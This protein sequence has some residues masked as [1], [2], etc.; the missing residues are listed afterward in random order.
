MPSKGFSWSYSKFKNYFTCAKRHYEVDLQRNFVD[1]SE[2]LR[3][4]NEVHGSLATA[5]SSGAPLPSSMPYQRWADE[6]RTGVFR[7]EVV[8]TAPWL[9]H[10][11]APGSEVQVEKKYAI[12]K[13]FTPT[14]WFGGDAW[15]R[16]ICDVARFDP[17]KTVALA[18]DYKTGKV[19]HD[20]RQLMLM[21]QCLFCHFPSLQRIRTEFVWLKEDC[22]TPE[23][24]NR[25]T[26]MQEWPPILE[27][28]KQMEHAANT[29]TYPPMPGRLCARYC[30]VVSCPFHGKR[31]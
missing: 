1:D 26:I 29:L 8:A 22:I 16:G 19:D 9:R 14:A 10:L 7:P 6:M 27:G 11:Q 20:S 12:T 17:T 25:N 23:T 18:R 28:V 24:F 4:G 30:P 13:N 21:A 31:N 15:Y 3:W 5:V 2:Q